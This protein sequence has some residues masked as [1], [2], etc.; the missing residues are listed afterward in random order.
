M[1]KLKHEAVSRYGSLR[2]LFR[3]IDRDGGGEVDFKEF[4]KAMERT[5]LHTVCGAR[6]QQLVFD[7]IDEDGSGQVPAQAHVREVSCAVFHALWSGSV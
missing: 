5:G 6:E 7:K 3:D 4:S 1:G 2:G